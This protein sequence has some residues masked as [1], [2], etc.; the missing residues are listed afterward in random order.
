[1]IKIEKKNNKIL[2]KE[3]I[4][5]VLFRIHKLKLFKFLF[6]N[7]KPK[8]L[9]NQNYRKKQHDRL[10]LFSTFNLKGEVTKNL[11]HYLKNLSDLGSD[12]VLVDTSPVSSEK[13]IELIRPYLKHYI[14]RENIGYDFGSWKTGLWETEDWEDYKQIVITNDSIYG[15]LH[16]LKPIFEKF[17]KSDYDVWG[18][19]DSYEFEHHIMSYFLVFQNKVIHSASFKKFWKELSFYPTRFKKL[20]ILEYEIGGTKYWIQNGFKVGSL[21]EYQKLDQNID[22]SFYINPTHVHWDTIVKDHGFP[23]IKR[24]LAKTLIAN[25]LTNDLENLLEKTNQYYHLDNIEL[26]S[27]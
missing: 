7:Q 2:I 25:G 16:S 15:P 1:M 17:K 23:F 22:S 9:N 27:K 13:E 11:R 24:D 19:T 4:L 8:I 18:L 14:W 26:I 21:I 12:I 6:L 20:L 3:F 10:V 5:K